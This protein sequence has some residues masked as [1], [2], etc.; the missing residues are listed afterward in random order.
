MAIVYRLA[1][2]NP[3]NGELNLMCH[4]LALLEAHH[5][6]QVSRIRVK[7][8]NKTFRYPNLLPS[9]RRSTQNTLLGPIL[10]ASIYPY[11]QTFT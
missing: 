8:G 9:L 1:L 6:L 10:E 4:L 11:E 7:K 3:L 5:I 2:V